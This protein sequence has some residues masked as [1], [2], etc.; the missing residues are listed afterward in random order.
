MISKPRQHTESELREILNGDTP[1]PQRSDVADWEAD[2]S[3]VVGAGI[4]YDDDA[5]TL[6]YDT[7]DLSV[8]IHSTTD[9]TVDLIA[10]ENGDY[11]RSAAVEFD[12]ETAEEIAEQLKL[13]AQFARMEE[14]A[15]VRV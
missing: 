15:D 10:D 9:G 12:P 6:Q 14:G 13:A 1:L 8:G 5:V 7:E 11:W 3:G 2:N 4:H